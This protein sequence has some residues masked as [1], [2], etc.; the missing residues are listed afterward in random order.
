LKSAAD[1]LSKPELRE[2]ADAPRLFLPDVDTVFARIMIKLTASVRTCPWVLDVYRLKYLLLDKLDRQRFNALSGDIAGIF[3]F[4]CAMGSAGQPIASGVSAGTG[5]L[6][7]SSLESLMKSAVRRINL[8]TPA[9]LSLLEAAD[10]IYRSDVRRRGKRQEVIWDLTEQAESLTAAA[11]VATLQKELISSSSKPT[12]ES[13]RNSDSALVSLIAR[14]AWRKLY[15]KKIVRGLNLTSMRQLLTM[16]TPQ[17]RDHFL[18]E[19]L[20]IAALEANATDL[21]EELFFRF[22][23][24]GYTPTALSSACRVAGA[25]RAR[26]SVRNR[27]QSLA[28]DHPSLTVRSAALEAL[29]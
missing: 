16:L 1:V 13:D 22:Q 20:L 14:N 19:C 17:P 28:S 2:G 3:D 29:L 5:R 21:A 27:L 25:M 9:F 23:E 12:G 24:P 18:A 6:D 7:E 4:L 26:P 10:L 15:L 11:F 8:E